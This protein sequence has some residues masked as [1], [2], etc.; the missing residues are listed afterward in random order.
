MVLNG[1]SV[2]MTY[3]VTDTVHNLNAVA[4]DNVLLS[5]RGGAMIGRVLG[6]AD[7]NDLPGDGGGEGEG[8]DAFADAVD[9]IFAESGLK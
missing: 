5:F 8:F 3:E 4:N 2:P 6:G 1:V 9:A 7:D